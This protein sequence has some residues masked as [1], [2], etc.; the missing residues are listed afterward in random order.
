MPPRAWRPGFEP[1]ELSFCVPYFFHQER[2][3]LC[4]TMVRITLIIRETKNFILWIKAMFRIQQSEFGKP[5]DT[6]RRSAE[7]C[8]ALSERRRVERVG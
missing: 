5:W 4:S 6:A 3:G 1:V 8:P 7:Q 2:R